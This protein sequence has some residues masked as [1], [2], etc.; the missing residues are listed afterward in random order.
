M[1][2]TP[3]EFVKI[4]CDARVLRKGVVG[5]CPAK[6]VMGGFDPPAVKA[7]ASK[8]GWK[9]YKTEGLTFCPKCAKHSLTADA[10]EGKLREV[11]I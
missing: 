8:S 11:A 1:I 4:T 9:I 6:L 3:G 5:Q 7:S 10:H 2:E